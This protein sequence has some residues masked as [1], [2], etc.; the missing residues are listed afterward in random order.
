MPMVSHDL[1]DAR[2]AI[3]LAAGAVSFGE[4]VAV[5]ENR[6]SGSEEGLLLLVGHAGHEAERHAC[7]ATLS[8]AL[9][10]QDVRDGVAG[11]GVA[12]PPVRWIEN[13]VEAGD[14]HHGRNVGAQEL[15][16]PLEHLAGIDKPLRGGA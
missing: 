3:H 15:V 14:E 4:A 8:D 12:Q 13:G 11:V 7:S 16:H 6:R 1:G 5:E 2:G 10:G 9:A